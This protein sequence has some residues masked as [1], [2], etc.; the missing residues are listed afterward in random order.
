MKT[1]FDTIMD[2]TG[3]SF[4]KWGYAS[5]VFNDTGVLPM[6]VADM[7]FKAPPAVIDAL[8]K[9]AEHGDFGYC[10][11]PDSFYEA[12]IAW[13]RSRHNWNITRDWMLFCPGGVSALN[14]SV[15]SFSSPGD[16]VIVQTPVY[17][18]FLMAIKNNDRE[19]LCNKLLF[20]DGRYAM[21]F[22]DLETHMAAGAK[23]LILCSP[24][25][26]VGRVWRR[27][28]LVSLAE[29]CKK[30]HV[31]LVSDEIHSDLVYTDHKHVPVASLSEQLLH[32]TVTIMA[33]SKTFNLAG[34]STCSVI[35][36]GSKLRNLFFRSIMMTGI[37]MTNTFG[38]PAFEAAYRH[39]AEWLHQ[40]LMYLED[41]LTFLL[42]F[43]KEKIPEIVPVKPEGTYLVWLDCSSLALPP[44]ELKSFFIKKAKVGLDDGAKFGPGGDAFQ[45]INIACPRSI[46]EEGLKRIERALRDV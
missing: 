8:K 19:L 25:N 29:L 26:P 1:D 41:N 27:E 2:R 28:E 35:I 13:V 15:M 10:V 30:Y 33:P 45:R 4:L 9:H 17:Y 5:K 40:L 23:L 20:K 18:P 6:W 12:V 24:H 37:D 44:H 43:F 34:L 21:D 32:S 36:P 11:R 22:N 14:L 3:P 16:K 42:N 38:I 39:G 7:D 46:L 31:V